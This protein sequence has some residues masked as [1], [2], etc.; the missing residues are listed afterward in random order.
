M[1]HL[2]R[3]RRGG[4]AAVF[5]HQHPRVT[6]SGLVQV[7]LSALLSALTVLTDQAHP[8]ASKSPQAF[9]GASSGMLP[10]WHTGVV[11]GK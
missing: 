2:S 9:S 11:S 7:N 4:T 5:I 8:A 3:N 1:E 10:A 6:G